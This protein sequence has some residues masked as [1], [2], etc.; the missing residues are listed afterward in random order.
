MS[1]IFAGMALNIVIKAKYLLLN[2]SLKS[3]NLTGLLEFPVFDFSKNTYTSNTLSVANNPAS[4]N[5]SEYPSFSAKIPP[6][7]APHKEPEK[8]DDKKVAMPLVRLESLVVS[9]T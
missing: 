5:V 8:N 1:T 6:I 9:E 7:A 2:S 4:I 3:F